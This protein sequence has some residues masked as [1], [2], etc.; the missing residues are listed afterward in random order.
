[1][2]SMC[3]SS[4]IEKLIELSKEGGSEGE[5]A[6]EVIG[7]RNYVRGFEMAV[8]AGG[9]EEFSKDFDSQIVGEYTGPWVP[10]VKA[11]D[12][13]LTAVRLGMSNLTE[14]DISNVLG[15]Y[16]NYIGR[17][18]EDS[19]GRRDKLLRVLSRRV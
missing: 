15:R 14:E 3:Q 1:M 7:N 16:K 10:K 19:F 8:R 6:R 5:L 17:A 2:E 4:Y 13:A 9:V 11:L 18:E 12:G